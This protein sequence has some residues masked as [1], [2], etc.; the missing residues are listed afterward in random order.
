MDQIQLSQGQCNTI[1]EGKGGDSTKYGPF[2]PAL[3]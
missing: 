3:C 2:H 1:R